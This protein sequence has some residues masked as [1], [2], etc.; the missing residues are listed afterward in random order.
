MPE[1]LDVPNILLKYES[2]NISELIKV[3]VSSVE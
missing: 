2:F 3:K 1:E